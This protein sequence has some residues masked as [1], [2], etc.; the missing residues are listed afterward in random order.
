M[1]LN[2]N[3]CGRAVF[4]AKCYITVKHIRSACLADFI[5]I[6]YLRQRNGNGVECKLSRKLKKRP[7]LKSLFAR[8]H[9]F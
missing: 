8:L 5:L 2:A 6:A 4:N 1:I 7:V 3:C 9:Y